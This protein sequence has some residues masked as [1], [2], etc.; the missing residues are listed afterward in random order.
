MRLF[1]RTALAAL[2]LTG[3]LPAC[4]GGDD[5]D[6]DA[7]PVADTGVGPDTWGDCVAYP[8][9]TDGDGILD[10]DEGGTS[11]DT[12]EDGT[13]D[14]FEGDTEWLVTQ[15][16]PW[17]QVIDAIDA[18]RAAQRPYWPSLEGSWSLGER[19]ER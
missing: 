1:V 19:I 5:D 2:L 17:P 9:D 15:R 18:V 14:P 10:T 7:G 4:G 3:T 12:D 11:V 6:T 16:P 13:P 8:T